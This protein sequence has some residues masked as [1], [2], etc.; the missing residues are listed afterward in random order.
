MGPFLLVDKSF[1]QSLNPNEIDF[2]HR[3]YATLITPIFMQEILGDL[4]KTNFSPDESLR[5][6]INLAQ[7]ADDIDSYTIC[8]A[9]GLCLGDLMG[10]KVPLGPQIPIPQNYCTEVR[11]S[12]GSRGLKIE[13]T[14][15]EKLLRN[16]RSGSFSD[17]DKAFA[18]KIRDDIDNYDPQSNQKAMQRDFPN[19]TKFKSLEEILSEEESY[20]GD[21]EYKWDNI[22]IIAQYAGT[23]DDEKQKI[24][25]R[26]Q[27]LNQPDIYSFAPYAGFCHKVFRLFHLGV[28]AGLVDTSRKSKS[29]IDV[30][31]FLYL[32]FVHAFCSSDKFHKDLFSYFARPDQ[33]FI[34]GPDLK[35]DLANIS[36]FHKNLTLDERKYFEK[37]FGNYPP[38]FH[39]SM[40][41]ITKKIWEKHMGIWKPGSGN[42]AIDMTKEEGKKLM[43]ELRVK[44]GPELFGKG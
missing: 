4:A 18:K 24:K 19:N 32:P 22:E 27:S 42:K 5:R 20:G 29:V 38:P 40:R 30:H 23:T 35:S 6:V 16:W 25:D 17:E 2:M 36:S 14:F 13:E 44:F 3:H 31:Y 41:S 7:K 28:T 33:D 26:W 21:A 9:R 43:D 1:I 11:A 39:D 8:D 37:E 12:D 15:E 34:W 10:A